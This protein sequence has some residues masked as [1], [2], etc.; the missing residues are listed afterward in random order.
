MHVFAL[1]EGDLR[2]FRASH[3]AGGGGGTMKRATGSICSVL[4][5]A[6]SRWNPHMASAK[7]FFF[8]FAIFFSQHTA[9]HISAVTFFFSCGPEQ[10]RE[11]FLNKLVS[12]PG[13]GRKCNSIRETSQSDGKIFHPWW[14]R[15]PLAVTHVASPPLAGM[16]R[17]DDEVSPP[18][19]HHVH[20]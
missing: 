8:F 2:G 15:E 11:P 14:P 4:P 10:F 12:L 6:F 5:A 18:S 1:R 13:S 9:L 20:P 3:D 19:L 17:L 16:L 7:S